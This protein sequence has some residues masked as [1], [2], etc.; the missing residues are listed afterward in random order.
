M[1]NVKYDVAKVSAR[2]I[3]VAKFA[4]RFV[5]R[6]YIARAIY[7]ANGLRRRTCD[8]Y[9]RPFMNRAPGLVA[10]YDT[11]QEN[12]VSLFYYVPEPTRG[13]PFRITTP[14]Y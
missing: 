13:V 12:E 8:R 6:S 7:V 2:A 9:L 1:S 5:N 10:S 3:S 4:T 11:G 14:T